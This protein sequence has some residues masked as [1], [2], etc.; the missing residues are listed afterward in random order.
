[1]QCAA[2]RVPRRIGRGAAA[3]GSSGDSGTPAWWVVAV[4]ASVRRQDAPG[5]RGRPLDL[6]AHVAVI[7]GALVVAP[8][9]I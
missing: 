6:L 7:G 9:W 4:P 5:I 2:G 3:G 8:A 1:M